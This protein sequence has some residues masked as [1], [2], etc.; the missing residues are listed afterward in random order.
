MRKITIEFEILS[1]FSFN[2]NDAPNLRRILAPPNNVG[3]YV[4]KRGDDVLY[5][6]MSIL[7]ARRISDHLRGG[8]KTSADFYEYV[9]NFDVYITE[10]NACADLLETYLI[11]KHDPPYNISKKPTDELRFIDVETELIE[12][13]EEIELLRE[14]K[15][16]IKGEYVSGYEGLLDES[17][18][19]Y[20][21]ITAIDERIIELQNRRKTL[22]RLGAEPLDNVS[23]FALSENNAMWRLDYKNK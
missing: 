18:C 20:H 1:N 13:D 19:V 2:V 3:T 23:Y 14:N 11:M 7:L 8:T 10:N 15:S 16:E 6:G 22:R 17:L 12:I 9:D 4:L 21:E 5:V